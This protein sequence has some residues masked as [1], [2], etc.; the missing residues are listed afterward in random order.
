M[1]FRLLLTLA[2]LITGFCDPVRAQ[3]KNTV[4]P[5]VR[6]QIEALNRQYDEAFNQNDAEA[7]AALFRADTVEAGPEEAASGQQEIEER[8]KILFES[9]PNGYST[10]LDQVYAIGSRICALAEWSAMQKKHTSQ[11]PLLKEGDVVAIDVRV[12]EGD[13]WKICMLYCS[14]K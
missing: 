10:K 4:D 12:R 9:H 13:A 11:P 5:Q 1:K 6:Q 2:G 3:E 14:Y 7:V 8:Y